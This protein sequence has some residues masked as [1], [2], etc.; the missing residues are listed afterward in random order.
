M[1]VFHFWPLMQAVRRNAFDARLK[2]YNGAPVPIPA[3]A[4][5]F[6]IP[7][8]QILGE[9]VYMLENYNPNALSEAHYMERN[10]Y[11]KPGVI[12]QRLTWM[13]ES[14]LLT[15][16]GD[17]YRL[18]DK[19]RT[20]WT[21]IK[22][23]LNDHWTLPLQTDIPRITALMSKVYEAMVNAPDAGWSVQTRATY[24]LRPEMTLTPI[25]YYNAHAIFDLWAR[26]DDAHLT[27]WKHHPVSPRTWEAL[28]TLWDG[29]ADDADLLAKALESHGFS[30]DDYAD[31]LEEMT[32][33]G[34]VE[35]TPEGKFQLT[36][37]GQDVRDEAERDT[38]DLFY[39]P[40]TKA[41][42][43]AEHDELRDLLTA[44]K[45]E[46]DTIASA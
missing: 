14:G 13:A 39:A 41:L 33:L 15:T 18:T 32:A 4:E 34:W 25:L 36:V 37:D 21:R 5:S 9:F 11:Y 22:E 44:L 1:T 26:R 43:T 24:S 20:V 46:L 7:H 10:C 38:D 12:A 16:E 45:A 8:M 29:K 28:S 27:A 42:S 35:K 40:F 31:S 3:L 6:G 2:Y 19:G 17:S 30:S 23:T